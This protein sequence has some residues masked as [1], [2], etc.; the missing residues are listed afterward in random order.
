MFHCPNC[1]ALYQVVKDEA[2][3]ETID[4]WVTCQ[5]CGGPLPSREGKFTL[6]YFL[7]RK[8]GFSKRA[9]SRRSHTGA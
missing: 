8:G 6:R 5:I 2:R 7:L 4:R 1:D 3:R 9:P